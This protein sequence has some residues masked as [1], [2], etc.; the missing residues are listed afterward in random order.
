MHPKYPATETLRARLERDLHAIQ[1]AL[2]DPTLD[3]IDAADLVLERLPSGELGWL[4]PEPRYVVTD[5]GRS[6][7]A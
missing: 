6:A 4:R 7:S 5:S 2:A 3:E 1:E